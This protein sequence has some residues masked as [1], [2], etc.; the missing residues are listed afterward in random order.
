MLN[1]KSNP[2]T[3]LVS[4]P[5]PNKTSSRCL[6]KPTQCAGYS[7]PTSYKSEC[8]SSVANV[9]TKLPLLNSTGSSCRS[10]AARAACYWL[11]AAAVT[12]LNHGC[13]SWQGQ[14]LLCCKLAPSSLTKLILAPGWKLWFP[15]HIWV[16]LVHIF[17]RGHPGTPCC[18]RSRLKLRKA[19]SPIWTAT[20]NF[21][22]TTHDLFASCD[23][24]MK[25]TAL[26]GKGE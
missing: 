1:I 2:I 5:L 22:R 24:K 6:S 9:T 3:L 7:F 10:G 21:P 23:V 18:Q 19:G 13:C 16:F 8:L 25:Y 12:L 15:S 4:F 26:T 11:R 14:R 20:V 17:V